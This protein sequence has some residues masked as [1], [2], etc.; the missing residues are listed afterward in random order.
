[1]AEAYRGPDSRPAAAAISPRCPQP[2][3]GRQVARLPHQLGLDYAIVTEA[4]TDALTE[5]VAAGLASSSRETSA[6]NEE[7][8]DPASGSARSV[9][10]DFPHAAQQA[11]AQAATTAPPPGQV[12]RTGSERTHLRAW[13]VPR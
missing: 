3:S 2:R 8:Q 10:R 13:R 12:G 6:P 1:V 5:V 4:I 7:P 11:I 9:G